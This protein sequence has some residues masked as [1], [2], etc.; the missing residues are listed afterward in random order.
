[1]VIYRGTDGKPGYHQ[2]EEIHD[3]VS[4]VERLRN[5]QSVEH[6]RIFRLEEVHFEFRPYYRV[7]LTLG[8]ALGAGPQDRS[9]GAGQAP[10]AVGDQPRDLPAAGGEPD[11]S[12]VQV[13]GGVGVSTAAPAAE[14]D[15]GVG[16][17]RG[18]F[19]R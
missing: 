11:H 2:T 5:E 3:A 6:A 7:E 9:V 19:G 8:S 1:M 17:R 12:T 4:F 16:A 13:P 18:L 15:N 10:G 14:G